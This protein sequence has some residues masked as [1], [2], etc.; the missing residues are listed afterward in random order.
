[1]KKTLV[2]LTAVLLMTVPV[3]LFAEG[4]QEPASA[5]ESSAAIE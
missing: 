3:F 2:L 5:G 1:M 4:Q